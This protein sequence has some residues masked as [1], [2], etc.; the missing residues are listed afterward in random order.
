MALHINIPRPCPSP[1]RYFAAK[2]FVPIDTVRI[3]Y[4]CDTT[5][6]VK[7]SLEITRRAGDVPTSF[8]ILRARLPPTTRL[9]MASNL[10]RVVLINIQ[11]CFTRADRPFTATHS[12]LHCHY[13]NASL[14]LSLS[15]G[16]EGDNGYELF[17]DF[18]FL[19]FD[20]EFI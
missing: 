16:S 11:L 19:F 4:S 18:Y 8:L 9:F 6:A 12:Q 17:L 10:L 5:L 2:S 14:L 1:S 13:G 20:N 15:L 7:L 3:L